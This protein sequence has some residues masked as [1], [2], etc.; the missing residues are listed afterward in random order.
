MLPRNKQT[1]G[2]KQIKDK[3]IISIE[4]L[5]REK[6]NPASN[7]RNLRRFKKTAIAFPI[8]KAIYT[9]ARRGEKTLK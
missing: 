2:K 1:R 4:M 6:M 9:Q 5:R 7:T 8:A 3:K